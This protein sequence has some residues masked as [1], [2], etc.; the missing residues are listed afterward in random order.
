MTEAQRTLL[1]RVLAS[2]HFAQAQSLQ[3][4][5]RYLVEHCEDSPAA[6]KEAEI[7][8]RALG[9]PA[10]FDPKIDPIVRVSMGAI[11]DRL[12]A[13]FAMDGR[14]EP[15]H[16]TIPRG[17]YRAVFSQM[18]GAGAASASPRYPALA[19]FWQPYISTVL[20]NA[21]IYSELLFFRD[22]AG[23]YVR[24]IFVND[25]AQGVE[26]LRARFPLPESTTLTASFH[27]LSAGEVHCSMAL[28]RS[29]AAAGATLEMRNSRFTAWN[30]IQQANLILIGS[31]RTNT[32]TD[33]LQGE[34]R[35][36]LTPE[37]INVRN[38]AAGEPT[39]YRGRRHREGKL[40]RLTEYAVITRRAGLAQGSSV[41]IVGANHGRAIEGA[42]LL[43]A[44]ENRLGRLLDQAF[45]GGKPLPAHFQLLLR[46]EL[47]D[48]DEEVIAVELESC[49][50]P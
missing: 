17:E 3:R 13:Y 46:V 9:R 20:P 14:Q 15:V 48:Y 28:M 34:E 1:A 25:V 22:D 49:H 24:N 23:N 44:E 19:R 18:D 43:L 33:A 38:A 50:C 37:Q 40:E 41:T 6:L 35:I 12:Q 8:V 16:L 11:R 39:T 7:A 47:I 4:I 42:G 31:S 45:P 27:F 32:F 26:D 2:P 21:L 29:F 36:V 30:E 10:P 5:L